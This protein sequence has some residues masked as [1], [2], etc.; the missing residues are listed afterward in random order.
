[1][2]KLLSLLVV[3]GFAVVLA[4][5]GGDDTKKKDEPKKADATKKDDAK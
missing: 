3:C 2:R 5:C 4:G 1:M